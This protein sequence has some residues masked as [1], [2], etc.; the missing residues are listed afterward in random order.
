MADLST[1]HVLALKL[2]FR[3]NKT[4]AFNLGLGK[5]YSVNE[6]IDAVK[7]VTGIEVAIVLGDR[8]HGDP[9]YLVAGSERA[10]TK[11][12]WQ[13][14]FSDLEQIVG[15]AWSWHRKKFG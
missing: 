9:P 7:N 8:R 14:E 15:S 11:L 3:E 6:V 13:P 5:G 10:C 4:D 2:Q 12:G 1:A